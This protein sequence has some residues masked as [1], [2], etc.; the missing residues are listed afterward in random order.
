LSTT[1]LSHYDKVQPYNEGAQAVTVEG[2]AFRRSG[3]FDVGE[4]ISNSS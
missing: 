4:E 1:K 3:D 2:K